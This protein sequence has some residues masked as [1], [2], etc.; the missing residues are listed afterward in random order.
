MSFSQT[1]RVE[2]TEHNEH[3]ALLQSAEWPS[4]REPDAMHRFLM[5][6]P[7]SSL[8][9]AQQGSSAAVSSLEILLCHCEEGLY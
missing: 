8:L 6:R 5:M 7:L 4:E 2:V 1:D 9:A 3:R